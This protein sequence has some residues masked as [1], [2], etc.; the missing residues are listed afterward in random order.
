MV[1]SVTKVMFDDGSNNN[2][3]NNNTSAD[4]TTTATTTTTSTTLNPN[5]SIPAAIV[6]VEAVCALLAALLRPQGLKVGR[7]TFPIDSLCC[8]TLLIHLLTHPVGTPYWHSLLTHPI[9]APID[10]YAASY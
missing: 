4:T 9:D 7:S 1:A 6:I 3:N 10:T 2:N 8:H 5:L